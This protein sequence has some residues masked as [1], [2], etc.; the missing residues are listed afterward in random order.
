[1]REDNRRAPAWSIRIPRLNGRRRVASCV[2]LDDSKINERHLRPAFLLAGAPRSCDQP[3]LT[4]PTPLPPS[5]LL[6]D[7]AAEGNPQMSQMLQ[8]STVLIC[9]HL[10]HLRIV[11]REITNAT[12]SV[13]LRGNTRLHSCPRRQSQWGGGDGMADRPLGDEY[14]RPAGAVSDRAMFAVGGL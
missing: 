5:A 9:V 6:Q 11:S 14:I 12:H 8:M 2:L 7:A 13:T 1:M 3:E 4:S 10:R